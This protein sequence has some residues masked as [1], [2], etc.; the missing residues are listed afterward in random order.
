MPKADG[1]IYKK[2][3]IMTFEEFCGVMKRENNEYG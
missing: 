2:D 1:G 3:N